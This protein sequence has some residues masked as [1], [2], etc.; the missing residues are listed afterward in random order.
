M[1]HLAFKEKMTIKAFEDK[2]ATEFTLEG[3]AKNRY[4]EETYDGTKGTVVYLYYRHGVHI[5][6]HSKGHGWIFASAYPKA[7]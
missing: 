7:A 4:V 3:I 6:S 5:G 1:S 2:L